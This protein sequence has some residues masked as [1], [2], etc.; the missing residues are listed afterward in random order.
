MAGEDNK[1]DKFGDKHWAQ[2]SED[3]GAKLVLTCSPGMPSFVNGLHP[4]ASLFEHPI[5]LDS[6]ERQHL[7][8]RN[9]LRKLGAHVFTVT[10]VLEKMDMQ[11]LQ[12][13]AALRLTYEYEG[14][15]P[16]ASVR[17][18]LTNEYK[19][20]V[21]D[22]MAKEQ[23]ITSIMMCP[24]VK[25]S[26]EA[27]HPQYN[28]DPMG[29]SVFTRDQQ[30]VTR[31]GL[32]M[33][34]MALRPRDGEV[35]VMR[36]CFR[37]LGI[38]PIGQIPAP[39]TLEGG[40]FIP[41]GDDLCFLG[42]GIRTSI[43]AAQYMLE[44]DLFGTS[45]VAV[46][47]DVFEQCQYRMHLDT[48]FNIASNRVALM[49]SSIIGEDKVH[50]RLV[51]EYTRVNGV[52]VTTK[53]DVE[54]S[55]YVAEEG[56]EIIPVSPEDQLQYV[57]NFLNAGNGQI[58]ASHPLTKTLLEG[59]K[60]F[61]G[62]VEV[63]PYDG[64][65]AMYGG[66]HCSTQVFRNASDAVPETPNYDGPV[67]R[68]SSLSTGCGLR[69]GR[70][71]RDWQRLIVAQGGTETSPANAPPPG[72]ADA[73]VGST[74]AQAAAT[75]TP[76][77]ELMKEASRGSTTAGET[78]RRRSNPGADMLAEPEPGD[79]ELGSKVSSHDLFLKHRQRSMQ[80]VVG[81]KMSWKRRQQITDTA[82]LMAPTQFSWNAETAGDHASVPQSF[83]EITERYG[84][85]SDE[86]L[87]ALALEEFS[88]LH[89][90]LVGAGVTVHLYTHLPVH[91]TPDAVF[92]RTWFSTHSPEETGGRD[93]CLV[94]YPL[95]NESRRRERRHSIIANLEM[96]HPRELNMSKFE[97]GTEPRY[98]EGQSSLVLDRINKVA[99]AMGGPR[100]DMVM[101]SIWAN[102]LKYEVVFFQPV[103]HVRAFTADILFIGTTF[104]IFC[105][106]VVRPDDRDAVIQR[107]EAT[108]HEIVYI[109]EHQMRHFC[110]NVA[111]L[112]IGDEKSALVLSA[113]AH[114][115]FSRN[116]V[117]IIQK[118][119]SKLI[120]VKFD[121]IETI[122][123][124]S[125][126]SC[127]A[128]IF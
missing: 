43:H 36:L 97:I 16:P 23:L 110:A 30:V 11:T 115:C 95:K 61:Q 106:D 45:R 74:K 80:A 70:P 59:S 103:K 84:W 57:C 10:E 60:N 50:R 42:V 39:F 34:R 75:S 94:L 114:S 18:Y 49:L 17:E 64:V 48:V 127:I 92:A 65:T 122:G 79:D 31:K 105:A 22:A 126:G 8:M 116:D 72:A 117:N 46:V 12:K 62:H 68:I 6:A 71:K 108:N 109:D 107:L 53:L 5:N 25:M 123:G 3:E 88:V 37:Q 24:C 51:T 82:L 111:Q 89:R 102:K 26:G 67:I 121:T 44:N 81:P 56:Y 20:S 119:V 21:V 85:R 112:R 90:E 28:F 91:N 58:L 118:H 13:L 2:A 98:L 41:A 35:K 55:K 7:Q 69:D 29:N 15:N 83:A 47:R 38:E 40:D 87:R 4:A 14:D 96:M 1:V 27:L 19:Y 52:Y 120:P 77:T 100:T 113:R 101:T 32:V 104:A 99:Y 66:I 9:H 128:E 124:S 54:F 93:A 78:M 33:G 125:V 76:A 73:A 86:E 63:I